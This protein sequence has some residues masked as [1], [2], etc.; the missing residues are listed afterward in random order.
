MALLSEDEVRSIFRYI[1]D[2]ESECELD[3]KIIQS[4]MDTCG[5]GTL[6]S[7]LKDGIY[8]LCDTQREDFPSHLRDIVVINPPT[9][10]NAFAWKGSGGP[11]TNESFD[12]NRRSTYSYTHPWTAALGSKR[13]SVWNMVRQVVITHP[14]FSLLYLTFT[15]CVH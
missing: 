14:S 6:T 7:A 10:G 2:E 11:L 3:F 13:G 9:E 4:R 5:V 8:L 12:L 15:G 1:H